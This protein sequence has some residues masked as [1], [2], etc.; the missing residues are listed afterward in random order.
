MVTKK[1]LKKEI[2][3]LKEQVERLNKAKEVSDFL[4]DNPKGFRISPLF[5][6]DV[7][8]FGMAWTHTFSVY[9]DYVYCGKMMRAEVCC[10]FDLK[11]ALV[12]RETE[13]T[14]TVRIELDG[15]EVGET[16]KL[17]LYYRIYKRTGGAEDMEGDKELWSEEEQNVRR[18]KEACD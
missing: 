2:D 11:D 13:E 18:N 9:L 15:A 16:E 6:G 7:L 3:D 8:A 12:V 5:N 17:I 1:Q 14:Y 10:A 4:R